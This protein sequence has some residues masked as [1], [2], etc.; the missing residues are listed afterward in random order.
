LHNLG[1]IICEAPNN[2]LDRFEGRL[3]Y[4][5]KQYPLD[6]NKLLLRGCRLRNTRWCYGVVVFAGK[7][8]KLMMNSGKTKFKR[9]SLDRFLNVSVIC[10]KLKNLF[11]D[12]N[13]GN[14]SIS[15]CYV[16]YMHN[17]VCYMGMGYRQEF[18]DL[19]GMGYD[20]RKDKWQF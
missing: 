11:L 9:T 4:K 14:S 19:L 20:D 5:D 18:Y 13:Y 17:F 3:V 10:F 16:P 1:K 8:T 15:S 12:F 7:E 6:N 2:K